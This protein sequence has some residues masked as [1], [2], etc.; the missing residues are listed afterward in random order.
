MRIEIANNLAQFS[1]VA[2]D[3]DKMWDFSQ[4][5]L[6][7]LKSML[8]I[9]AVKHF[10]Q[11]ADFRAILVYENDQLIAGLPLVKSKLKN[12]FN[13]FSLPNNQWGEWGDLMVD[14]R[15]ESPQIYQALFEGLDRISKSSLRFNRIETSSKAWTKFLGVCKINQRIIV[16]WPAWFVGMI[17]HEGHW[18]DFES[19]L[20]KDFRKRLS[21]YH[22]RFAENGNLSFEHHSQFDEQS[23]DR[24]ATLAFELENTSWKG[25]QGG[26]VVASGQLDFFL[27]NAQQLANQ[28][29]LR[30]S[31]LRLDGK[32]IAFKFG[33]MGKRTYYSLKI[34]YNS[35][36]AR[37]APGHV[38]AQ[39]LTRA[40]H[41][42]GCCDVQ[43]SMGPVTEA[44]KRW[45]NR[46]KLK[47]NV[48]VSG[49]SLKSKSLLRLYQLYRT[50]RDLQKSRTGP[51]QPAACMKPGT[52]GSPDQPATIHR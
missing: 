46:F 35:E 52:T 21:K 41:D 14:Q 22:R 45:S 31:F 30:I 16:E 12:I 34:G 17:D 11:P 2:D 7:T 6:P 48:L 23:L 26:S 27:K 33:A 4:A 15:F 44:T 39:F 38:L 20:S 32:P 5:S 3:W 47:S 24:Y 36:F 29:S 51:S 18:P 25:K 40:F 8:L 19:R 50:L 42:T 28:N 9:S 43:D 37:F 49:R 1:A 13:V 10:Y